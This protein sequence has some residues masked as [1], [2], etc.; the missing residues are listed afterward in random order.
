[1]VTPLLIEPIVGAPYLSIANWLRDYFSW[2]DDMRRAWQEERLASVL[3]S[4]ALRV[5]FYRSLLG[6]APDRPVALEELPVVDKATIRADMPAFLA[7]D[8][9]RIPHQQKATAGT[10]GDPFNYPLDRMAWAHIYGAR[11][12]LWERTG[13]RYG[14]EVIWLGTPPS[15]A[16]GGGALHVRL[17][18]LLER[19]TTSVAGVHVDPRTSLRR[20]QRA[21]QAGGVV[22]YGY[23]G[24]VAALADAA[25]SLG[26]YL[27]GPRAI[28]TTSET[29]LP[30]WRR[31]IERTFHCPLVDE[32]GCN[33]GGIIA[34][35]CGAGRFHIAENVSIVEILEGDEPC[36]P[37][38]EGDV[39]VTNLHAR[40]LPF[41][42]YRIGD[43]AALGLGRCPCGKR[44]RTLE[45]LAGRSGDTIAL[46]DGREVNAMTFTQVFWETPHVRRWQIVQSER[47]RITVRLDVEHGFTG[48]EAAVVERAV[49]ERVGDAVAVDITTTEQFERTRGEKHRVVV[50]SL[51]R[52]G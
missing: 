28:V 32:Y 40:A 10:T 13:Y 15:L 51:L 29:L 3:R 41:L 25:A 7:D 47:E 30:E 18:A 48:A 45:R 35:S 6:C 49:R 9:Q 33:D 44:G 17:R 37:G 42:R 36:P 4:A 14:D 23:A 20:F 16:P 26:E 34:L 2:S 5:P 46:P 38:T 39:V 43:R 21:V 22:W 1:M 12:H 50:S 8:W 52:P 24:I 31:S 11:I 19:R 27:H